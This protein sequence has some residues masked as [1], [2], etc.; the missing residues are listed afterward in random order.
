MRYLIL[1]ICFFVYGCTNKEEHLELY[2][3]VPV[4]KSCMDEVKK[5]KKE[6]EEFMSHDDKRSVKIEILNFDYYDEAHPDIVAYASIYGSGFSKKKI[7]LY[8]NAVTSSCFHNNKRSFENSEAGLVYMVTELQ[9]LKNNG[10]T[11]VSVKF[12]DKIVVTYKKQMEQMGS[13]SNGTY[14]SPTNKHLGSE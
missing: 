12:E 5:F 3:R 4:F 6:K 2:A 13:D 1:I 11:E 14:L 10:V 8:V 9:A 7:R